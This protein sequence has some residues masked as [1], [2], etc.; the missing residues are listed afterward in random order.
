MKKILISGGNGDFP[1]EIIKHN[2]K[3]KIFTPSKNYSIHDIN[4][5][6][7]DIGYPVAKKIYKRFDDNI[8]KKLLPPNVRTY[9]LY[10]IKV[11]TP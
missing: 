5:F 1:K 4:Q 2:K 11:D 8:Q 7:D 9:P 10:G 3:F 6:F